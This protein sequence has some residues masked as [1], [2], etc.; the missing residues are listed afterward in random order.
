MNYREF[1]N[2]IF[3]E[4]KEFYG[5]DATVQIEKIVKNNGKQYEGICITHNTDSERNGVVPV[6]YLNMIYEKYISG[7]LEME[8]CIG[9][10]VDLR[11]RESFMTESEEFVKSITDWNQIKDSIYPVLVSTEGNEKFLKNL[12]T[13]P[14]LDL[15]IIYMIRSNNKHQEVYNV[16]ITNSL[17]EWYGISREDLHQQA[18]DNLEKDGYAFCDMEKLLESYIDKTGDE[19]PLF[20]RKMQSGKMYILT[21]ASKMYGAAGILYKKLLKEQLENCS[22]YILPS[23]LH[24]TI[25]IPASVGVDQADLDNMVREVNATQVEQEERLTN[26]SYFYDAQKEEIR[27]V[28]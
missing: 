28:A 23:S 20:N 12:M 6:I 13:E 18:F 26:H 24:E 27:I 21:N 19:E 7:K 2:R 17:V 25:F 15:S 22:C 5:K 4:L 10:I 16:K 3:V 11:E 8:D 1:V 14:F 9:M